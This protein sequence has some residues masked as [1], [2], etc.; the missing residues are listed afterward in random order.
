MP[1]DKQLIQLGGLMPTTPTNPGTCFTLEALSYLQI[2]RLECKVTPQAMMRRIRRNTCPLHPSTVPDRYLEGLRV[3]REWTVIESL[4]VHGY[5]HQPLQDWKPPPAGGLF[6]RCVVCPS[7]RNLPKG[8]KSDL[9]SWAFFYSFVHDGNFS[10]QHTVSLQP[11]NN[12]PIFPG[13]GAFQDPDEIKKDLASV[14][15]DCQLRKE[16]ELL[17]AKDKPCHKHVAA[18][19]TG[20][21]RDK[22][23]DIKGIGA[24]A[25]SRHGEFL[26]GG[27]CNYDLGEASGPA[28]VTLNN[29]F[30]HNTNLTLVE[31]IQ[32]LSNLY[33]RRTGIVDGEILETL[34]SVLNQILEF[35][36]GMS[37]AN[38]EE[39]IT[40]FESDSNHHKNLAMVDTLVKKFNKYVAEEK[41]REK[42]VDQLSLCTSPENVEQWEKDRQEFECDRINDPEAADRFFK[43]SLVQVPSRK[44]TE[45][46]LL[47]QEA[48]DAEGKG[49]VKAVIDAVD[50]QVDQLKLQALEK[51][52]TAPS[53]RR[54]IAATRTKI[55]NHVN[56]CNAAMEAA[57]GGPPGS[58]GLTGVKLTKL[59]KEDEWDDPDTPDPR[60]PEGLAGARGPRPRVLRPGA[61]FRPVDL[62]SSRTEAWRA[63]ALTSSDDDDVQLRRRAMEIEA[64]VLLARMD[65]TLGQLRTLIVDQA[66]I[67]LHRIRL[68]NG[69]HNQGYHQLNLAYAD[70]QQQGKVVRVHAQVYNICRERLVKLQWDSASTTV[71]RFTF[72][73]KKYR[74]LTADDLHCSTKTYSTTGT[75]SRFKLPWF[76]RMVPM[77]TTEDLEVARALDEEFVAEFFRVR[78]INAKCSLTWCREELIILKFEMQMCY[79]SYKSLASAWMRRGTRMAGSRAHVAMAHEYA[80]HWLDMAKYAEG[81]FNTCHKNVI[82]KRLRPEF[83]GA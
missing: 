57:L 32:L 69:N 27:T 24:W 21:T 1:F 46:R 2:D 28:D 14:K 44:D 13:T 63:P 54:N 52:A 68:R 62:P 29:S 48:G 37:L 80:E 53:E 58:G 35:C 49:I 18:Q 76:W 51:Q 3:M 15:T 56:R 39:V 67:Y 75:A 9:N 36:W 31:H 40:M 7:E 77:S 6:H 16:A 79:L 73:R 17:F 60:A 34:W 55:H 12:V 5:A 61:E 43:N 47:E 81:K 8:Y 19:V 38:R 20:K 66:N 30:K 83:P 42:L 72:I 64:S 33:A 45:L 41:E 10:A 74:V 70:A 4:I 25:C 59:M 50:L 26:T 78:W 23:T 71:D 11:G 82:S 22:I 65:E